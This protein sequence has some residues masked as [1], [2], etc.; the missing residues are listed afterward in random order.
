MKNVIINS[1]IMARSIILL[2]IS[3]LFFVAFIGVAFRLHP[4]EIAHLGV[5]I[6]LAL[7]A[8]A[9]SSLIGYFAITGK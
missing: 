2:A 5:R 1:K 9:V 8:F 7:F 3:V 4:F 6:S